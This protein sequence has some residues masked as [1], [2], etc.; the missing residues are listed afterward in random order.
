M[1]AALAAKVAKWRQAVGLQPVEPD[2]Y[3]GAKAAGREIYMHVRSALDMGDSRLHARSLLCALGAV[4]GHACQ[5]SVR[6]QSAA[7]GRGPDTPFRVIQGEDGRR[8]LSG[9]AMNGPLAEH[10]MS[11]WNLAAGAAQLHGTQGLPNLDEIF[12]Y[13]ASVIGTQKFG[14]PR[15]P[16]DQPVSGMPI[17]F[18]KRLWPTAQATVIR[19]TGNPKLWPI[20]A[21]LAVQEAIAVTKEIISPEIAVRIVME[22]AI[23]VSKIPIEA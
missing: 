7:A 12:E 19:H 15:L 13:N 9:D 14:L 3:L 18:A 4:A 10:K 16:R 20:A 1:I 2:P 23:P 8:Y 21:A 11:V 22:S 5:A 6:A 17:E